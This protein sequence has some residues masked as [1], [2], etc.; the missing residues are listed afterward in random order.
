MFI[1]LQ[2]EG[3]HTAYLGGCLGVESTTVKDHCGF[4]ARVA[5]TRYIER[6]Y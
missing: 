6:D 1:A 2:K 4:A 3:S 5:S